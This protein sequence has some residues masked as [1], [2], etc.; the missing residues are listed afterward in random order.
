MVRLS[1]VEVVIAE[2][3]VVNAEE[4]LVDEEVN[5]EEEVEKGVSCEEVV[6]PPEE[7]ALSSTCRPDLKLGSADTGLDGPGK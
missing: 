5:A 2:E 1:P 7:L 3:A 4:G 6:C